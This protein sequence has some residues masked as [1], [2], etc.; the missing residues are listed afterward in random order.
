MTDERK[1]MAEKRSGQ[2]WLESWDE[3][4]PYYDTKGNACPRCGED[5][6]DHIGVGDTIIYGAADALELGCRC[7]KCSLEF[8][9]YWIWL[10]G[11][12]SGRT[13]LHYSGTTVEPAGQTEKGGE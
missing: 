2:G 11:T 7:R 5:Y 8:K 12:N 4:N 9:E 13:E 1:S 3:G 6:P 10:D